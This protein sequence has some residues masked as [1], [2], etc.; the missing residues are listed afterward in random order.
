MFVAHVPLLDL[1]NHFKEAFSEDRSL[2]GGRPATQRQCLE[3]F[4]YPF[5]HSSDLNKAAVFSGIALYHVIF[6]VLLKCFFPVYFI[7]I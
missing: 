6:A 2:S 7:Q 3:C 5:A 4:V 1:V